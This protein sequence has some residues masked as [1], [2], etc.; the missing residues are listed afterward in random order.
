M[1][2]RH[3]KPF[4]VWPHHS[5]VNPFLQPLHT[6][7]STG[8]PDS[9]CPEC[10]PCTHAALTLSIWGTSPSHIHSYFWILGLTS[11]SRKPSLISLIMRSSFLGLLSHTVQTF[12]L[13]K[14]PSI[15]SFYKYASGRAYSFYLAYQVS[16]IGGGFLEPPSWAG[17]LWA[18]QERIHSL[19]SHVCHGHR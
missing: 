9:Q 5:F 10:A 4:V 15:F 2:A 7:S 16:F 6:F 12:G 11:S 18:Q 1:F 13:L 19:I 17:W 14:L 3:S 8:L